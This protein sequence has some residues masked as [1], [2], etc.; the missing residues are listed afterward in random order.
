MLFINC[1]YRTI[2]I[3]Q[4]TVSEHINRMYRTYFIFSET[5]PWKTDMYPLLSTLAPFCSNSM[6]LYH[7]IPTSCFFAYT[8]YRAWYRVFYPPLVITLLYVRTVHQL[9]VSDV[10]CHACTVHT[11]HRVANIYNT[12]YCTKNIEEN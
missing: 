12:N 3:Y 10:N 1:A 4:P 11:V 8:K 6:T 5:I 7:T 9:S 2:Q